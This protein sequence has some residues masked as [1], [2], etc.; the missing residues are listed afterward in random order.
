MAIMSKPI[1][2]PTRVSTSAA[3]SAVPG[4]IWAVLLN[5]GTDDTSI[6]FTNDANGSGTNVF[7]LEAPH[8]T[9]DASS[10]SSVYISFVD[11]GGVY[12][13]SKCYAALTGTAATAYVW[14]A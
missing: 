14:Y 7:E 12:F 6:E 11:V 1:C 13:S 10:K 4:R 9:S 3:I 5:G 8:T 2:A